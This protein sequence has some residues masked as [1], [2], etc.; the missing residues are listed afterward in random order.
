MS[1]VQQSDAVIHTH[2]FL[3]FQF[4]CHV[5]CHRTL[6]RVPCA[7]RHVPICEVSGMDMHLVKGKGDFVPKLVISKWEIKPG[8]NTMDVESY[9]NFVKKKSLGIIFV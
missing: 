7:L 3:L 9:K 4:F 5:D 8:T 1:A 2:T 6:G